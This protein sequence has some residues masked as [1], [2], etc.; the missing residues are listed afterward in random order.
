MYRDTITEN[1]KHMSADDARVMWEEEYRYS[2]TT[3]ICIC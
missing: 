1:Y 3:C 2:D